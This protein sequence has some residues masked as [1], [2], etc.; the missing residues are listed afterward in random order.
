MHFVWYSALNHNSTRRPPSEGRKNEHC[1][2]RGKK[3]LE[4]L[5]GPAEGGA[6]AVEVWRGCGRFGGQ[7]VREDVDFRP[8]HLLP[9]P[10]LI[11]IQCR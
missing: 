9:P 7:G 8:T 1:G 11:S 2:G 4:I 6:G 3:K 10:L 5:G